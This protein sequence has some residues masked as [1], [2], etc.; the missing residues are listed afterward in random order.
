MNITNCKGSAL[1][2]VLWMTVIL[3]FIGV[4]LA[5][6][7]RSEVAATQTLSQ[8]EQGYFLSRAGIEA[9]LLRMTLE[10]GGEAYRDYNFAFA[11]GSVHVEYLP[12]SAKYDVNSASVPLLQALFERLGQTAADA[13]TL[14]RQIKD[15]RQPPRPLPSRTIV[16][17]EELL[18]LPAMTTSLYY[19]DFQG[20]KRRPALYELLGTYGSSDSVNVNYVRPELLAL[21]PGMNDASVAQMIALRPLRSLAPSAYQRKLNL[22]DSIAFT[23]I[24]HGRAKD[25]EFDRTVRAEYMRDQ[26]RPLGVRLMAWH[27]TN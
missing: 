20:G 1:L 9:A 22:D 27:D 25:A 15:Y 4:T 3:S 24:A 8:G 17:L 21:M 12:A 5:S 26:K 7:V 23:L 16:S 2:A 14:A 19:G 6:T 18:A 10:H 11:T 13:E